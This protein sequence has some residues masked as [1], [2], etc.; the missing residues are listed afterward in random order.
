MQ[1]ALIIISF[2]LILYYRTIKYDLVID[3]IE[4]YRTP[5][6]YPLKFS[7]A[8]HHFH[9]IIYG[10]IGLPLPI[11]HAITMSLHI[12]TAILIGA[13]SGSLV[14]ALLYSCH[15][16]THQTAIWLN[17]RRY[18]ILNLLI[19]VV[20]MIHQKIILIPLVGFV[21]Y[22]FL[23]RNK[24]RRLLYKI[25]RPPLTHFMVILKSLGFNITK[26][27]GLT[28]IMSLYPFLE[29]DSMDKL[30]RIDK[31]AI[32]GIITIIVLSISH[33]WILLLLLLGS[34]TIPYTQTCADRYLS[35][36]LIFITVT[37]LPSIPAAPALIL[38]GAFFIKTWKL[39]KMYRNIQSFYD[40]HKE[41]FPEL[42][43]LNLL[44]SLYP[45][46]VTKSK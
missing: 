46:I 14:A 8:S 10:T 13:W 6:Q 44:Q 25:K 15:P 12:V 41:A 19:L 18:A 38:V 3:D 5:K 20:V 43:K 22:H 7:H 45:Q 29:K 32:I 36:P 1:D 40:Y 27:L 30:S 37:I 33:P 23:E 21:I 42:S 24:P 26:L 35:L 4:W 28:P 2:N 31:Y 16:A 9:K 17:G 11:E 39:Q 34:S